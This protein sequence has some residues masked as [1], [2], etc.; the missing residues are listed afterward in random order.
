M[1]KRFM[2]SLVA[3]LVAT[4]GFA[5]GI[6]AEKSTSSVEEA[7]PPSLSRSFAFSIG[8][9]AGV[10]YSMASDP[11]GADLGVGGNIGFGGGIAANIRF[12]KRPLAKFADTGRFGVQLEAMYSLRSIKTDADDVKFNAVEIPLLFQWWFLRDLCVEVGPTFVAGLSTSP[13]EL[14][15]DR[16]TYRTG[17]IKGSDVMV[18]VGAEYKNRCGFTASLRYNLGTS[19]LA[20]N[21]QTKVSTLSV[22][23]GWMFS[24]VK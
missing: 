11:D 6:V 23:I 14:Q 16:V 24:V 12:G 18:T 19:E 9:K 8:P 20:N 7:I 5:Q 15:F 10:N 22:G 2:F 3:F 4:M 21:F 1:V 17:D 13:D